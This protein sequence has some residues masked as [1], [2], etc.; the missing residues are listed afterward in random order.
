VE[1]EGRERAARNDRDPVLDGEPDD[2]T[3]LLTVDLRSFVSKE[4]QTLAVPRLFFGAIY[5]FTISAKF[6]DGSYGPPS[7]VWLD[8]TTSASGRGRYLFD[9]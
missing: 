1:C 3:P 5:E 4:E 9:G 8:T 2:V 6:L 7:T